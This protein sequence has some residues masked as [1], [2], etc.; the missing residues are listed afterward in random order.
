MKQQHN[1]KPDTKKTVSGCAGLG[2]LRLEI[3]VHLVPS[4]LK[5]RGVDKRR[6]VLICKG[7]D[8]K[9]KNSPWLLYSPKKMCHNVEWIMIWK[10]LTFITN[11]GWTEVSINVKDTL[12]LNEIKLQPDAANYHSQ[13]MSLPEVCPNTQT[14]DWSV[15][16]W[17]K[18]VS[19]VTAVRSRSFLCPLFAASLDRRSLVCAAWVWQQTFLCVRGGYGMKSVDVTQRWWSE[20]GIK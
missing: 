9:Q 14:E 15:D 20:G 12:T 1:T 5:G 10:S 3:V 17:R 19:C 2:S 11:W 18:D 16:V 6:W 4:A 8:E 13:V 7:D